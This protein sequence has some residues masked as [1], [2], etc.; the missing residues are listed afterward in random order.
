MAVSYGEEFGWEG[1]GKEGG[2]RCF[3]ES[4]AMHDQEK[5]LASK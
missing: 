2:M 5:F 3:V 4:I 1:E